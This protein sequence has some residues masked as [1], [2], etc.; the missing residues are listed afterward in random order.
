MAT[1]QIKSISSQYEEYRNQ[2][3]RSKKSE[4]YRSKR[5]QQM[6][7]AQK[8]LESNLPSEKI[9]TNKDEKGKNN[10]WNEEWKKNQRDRS[11]EFRRNGN[12]DACQM[13]REESWVTDESCK[14][15]LDNDLNKLTESDLHSMRL[16]GS[17]VRFEIVSN[18][19]L[20]IKILRVLTFVFISFQTSV[21]NFANSR[22][23]CWPERKH[24]EFVSV[25]NRKIIITAMTFVKT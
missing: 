8:L 24:D 13:A 19:V 23:E 20:G 17:D 7:Q 12:D 3:K 15:T 2:M 5:N 9:I 22:I 18:V 25:E 21:Q 4:E 16:N 6:A 11:S 14:S 1:Q 10:K